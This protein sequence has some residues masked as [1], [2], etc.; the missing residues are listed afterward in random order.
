MFEQIKDKIE[1]LI[2]NNSVYIV[3]DTVLKLVTINPVY[4]N[5]ETVIVKGLPNNVSIVTQNVPGSFNGM[6]VKIQKKN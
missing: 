3:K 6:V 2:N 1:L 4:F 5:A